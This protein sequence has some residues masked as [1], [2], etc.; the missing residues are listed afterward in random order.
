M[1]TAGFNSTVEDQD[2]SLYT[3]QTGPLQFLCH[4]ECH[5]PVNGIMV[6]VENL[7]KVHLSKTI[8]NTGEGGISVYSFITRI[9]FFKR[10]KVKKDNTS[11]RLQN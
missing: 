4:H 3:L 10:M 8:S 1:K 6:P 11:I 5:C 2:V 7:S 9:E